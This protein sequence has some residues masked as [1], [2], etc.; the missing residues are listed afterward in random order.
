MMVQY[1]IHFK[2]DNFIYGE[3]PPYVGN[4]EVS[5]QNDVLLALAAGNRSYYEQ[6]SNCRLRKE[7]YIN[8]LSN[9]NKTS[10]YSITELQQIVQH[11]IMAN[12]QPKQHYMPL[13][14]EPEV[15]V[16]VL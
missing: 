6:Q 13:I 16:C 15:Q 10:N 14:I 12:C 5:G 8:A 7:S 3:E 11:C 1:S 4:G 9:M 2:E